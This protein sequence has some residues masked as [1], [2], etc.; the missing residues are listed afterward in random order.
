[1]LSL[2]AKLEIAAVVIAIVAGG[3]GL[4]TWLSEHEA[5]VQA[6]AQAKAQEVVQSDL[7]TQINELGTEMANRDAAYQEQLKTLDAKFATA[8]NPNQITQLVAQLMGL[9]QPIQIVTP[10]ATP[11]NPNPAPVA[12]VSTL[13]APQVKS[14]VQDCEQCKLDRT[15]LTADAATRQQQA[16]LA[17]KQIA[18]LQNE[19]TTWKTAAKGGTTWQRL[20]R[21]AKWFAIG[22]GVGAAAVCGSGHCK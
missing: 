22:A 16:E 18:S 15:K 8:Q 7:K 5:R 11:G 10:A 9:K 6:E 1:M 3:F 21:G 20:K 14:Y 2:R 19:V 17:Q 4:R 13:D 12:Q